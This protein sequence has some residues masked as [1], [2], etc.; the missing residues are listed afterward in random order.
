MAATRWTKD[1]VKLGANPTPLFWDIRLDI[2]TGMENDAMRRA[3]FLVCLTL[4]L[5]IVLGAIFLGP[6]C[7]LAQHLPVAESWD[8]VPSM[9]EVAARF[10]GKTGTVLH[11]GDSITYANPYGQWARFGKGQSN[12][13]K[14]V[15]Q[16]MHTGADND[17][18]GWYLARFDHPGGGRS[19]TACSGIRADEM[20][21][22]GKRGMPSLAD[23]LVQYRPQ[24]VV[25]MFGTNDAS[26]NRPVKTYRADMQKAVD[27]I[28]GQGAICIL[29]TIPPHPRHG[30]LAGA[31]NKALREIARQKGLPLIDY[32]QE[33]LR[34][35]PKDFNGTLLGAG[36]VHPSANFR[37]TTP[38][39]APTPENLRNSGY[40]L[41]GWLSVKKIGEVKRTVLDGLPRPATP[42]VSRNEPSDSPS[43][44]HVSSRAPSLPIKN[45]VPSGEA[46]R[47]EI[48]RDAWF[49]DVGHEADCNTGGAPRLKVKSYQEMSLLDFDPERLKGRVIN[50]VT[51]HVGLAS[52]E[53]LRRITVGS[54]G[55]PW[56]EGTSV[57][58]APEI[59]SSSFNRQQHPD[60]L[61]AFA[62]SDLTAVMLGSGGTLWR[63]ADARPNDHR[64]ADGEQQIPVDPAV[65]AARVAGISH[66]LLV[67]DDTGSEWTRRG[68][69]FEFRHMPNRF[70]YSRQQRGRAVPYLTVYLGKPDRQPPTA[71][72][73]LAANIAELPAGEALVSWETPAD[74]G[75]AGTLGFF[76]ELGGKPVPRYL[77]PLA[78]PIGQRVSMRLRDLELTPGAVAKLAVRAVDAAGNQGPAA[79][80]TFRVSDRPQFDLPGTPPQAFS[81]ENALPALGEATVAI[82]DPLDKVH[83][84][85]GQMIPPQPDGYPAANHLWSAKVGQIRL[86]AARNEFVAFQIA[87]EGNVEGLTPSLVFA[88][89]GD[90]PQVEFGKYCYVQSKQGPLPDPIVPLRGTFDLPDATAKLDGQRHGSLLCEVYVPHNAASGGH[91]GTLRLAAN[92]T[93]V[94]VPVLLWVWDF[95]LPDYLSFLPEMNCYGL[96]ENEGDYYRLAH[97]HR[98][99]LN[100]LPYSQ[101]GSIHSGCAPQWDGQHLDFS[102]WD[103]RFG[104]FLD[105]HAF[106]DLPRKGVPLEVFYLPLHE[107]WPSEIDAYYNDSYWADRAF[108]PGYREAFVAASGQ[109]AEHFEARGW[110]DTIFQ[111]YLNNKNNYKRKGWSRGSSPWLL[112]EPAN[113]QDF[114]A[115]RYFGEA[116]HEGVHNALGTSGNARLCYR[117]DISR[118]QWQRNTLDHVLDYNVVGGAAFSKYHRMVVDR[119]RAFGQI[120]VPYGTNNAIEDSNMQAVG[121]C[122]DSWTEEGDGVLPWQTIGRPESWQEADQLSLFYPGEPVG[123]KVPVPSIRLKAYRRGQQDVEYLTLLTQQL[124]QPRWA[125]GQAVRRALQLD[126]EHLGTGHTDDEDAGAVHYAT[127]RPQ[128]VWAVRIRIAQV[129]SR[130]HPEPRRRLVALRTPPRN[131]KAGAE[132]YVQGQAAVVT[133]AQA[134][135]APAAPPS[136]FRVLQGREVVRD[137]IIDPKLPDQPV[138]NEARDNRLR[139]TDASGALLVRFD[140]SKLRLPRNAKVRRAV[141]SFYVWDPSSRGNSKVC[142]FGVKSLW[143]EGSVTWRHPRKDGRWRGRNGFAFGIDTGQ[144]SRHIVVP[145]DAG[146]DTVDP[147]LEYQIDVTRLVR[148]WL[149][150][151]MPNHGLAIAPVI[152][153]AID[154][155]NWTRMQILASEAEQ[156]EYT[157]KLTIEL[158]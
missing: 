64:P 13:D 105:G 108:R 61:W 152:D 19:Y 48:T 154:E 52:D 149:S 151:R 146:T 92:G 72:T 63:M 17:T 150:G 85:T 143:D 145:P 35:R 91:T 29:S 137:A 120:V 78:G 142:A 10:Q 65:L 54:F 7:S 113:F 60:L 45:A 21:A 26:A 123:L 124:R 94:E 131:P 118:P 135:S 44:G 128:D 32:E 14:A 83:P 100:R 132:A 115:L 67:F 81:K 1:A 33:I 148:D 112:D 129:L 18:D 20:L 22:G 15:L 66:G 47:V 133:A 110:H 86:A 127:L 99:V 2:Q 16:W 50:G 12:D 53:L 30:E 69:Q 77:I 41:R 141:V 153:P 31:Y 114:W 80:L 73:R 71:P 3:T 121:W 101:N 55:S 156:T 49:S 136:A 111:C 34:R 117:C 5:A 8:Y 102:A 9:K 95:T 11:V 125:V 23:L 116:F 107:N 158:Q 157:P 130:S 58:Y 144:P 39:S 134:T 96:P 24:M 89:S 122:L 126:A 75:P 87:L 106:D 62:G 70:F 97:R 103:R 43:P 36:D 76:V 155:G 79:T 51:L 93:I 104:P 68:E 57:S 138:G 82:L 46:V 37:G 42:E 6:R 109:M 119:K 25:L 74:Q 56:V 28:L 38:A 140:L 59:G 40:L 4:S 139:R 27:T 90:K 147:P 88:A 84:I 98:T